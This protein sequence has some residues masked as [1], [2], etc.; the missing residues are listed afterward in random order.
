MLSPFM[1]NSLNILKVIFGHRY[2]GLSLISHV[3]KDGLCQLF[4]AG[5]RPPEGGKGFR[6]EPFP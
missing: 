5:E 6:G 4:V 3:R 1:S 2:K